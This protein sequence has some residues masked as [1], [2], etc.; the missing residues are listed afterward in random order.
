MVPPDWQD[1]RG[2]GAGAM[3]G[4]THPIG[5]PAPAGPWHVVPDRVDVA[6]AVRYMLVTGLTRPSMATVG[7]PSLDRRP[8]PAGAAGSGLAAVCPG[9]GGG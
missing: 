1:A 7:A 8:A 6:E 4:P 2:K 9:A 3:I 5:E